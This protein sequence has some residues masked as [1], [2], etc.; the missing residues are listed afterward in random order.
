MIYGIGAATFV[1]STALL[2]Y[3]HCCR[4]QS[5]NQN[6]N[7]EYESRIDPLFNVFE[8]TLNYLRD[9]PESYKEDG[10]WRESGSKHFANAAY[11][12]VVDGNKTA[13]AFGPDRKFGNSTFTPHDAL[14]T[15]KM[16]LESNF[17]PQYFQGNDLLVA[18]KNLHID[19]LTVPAILK[20]HIDGLVRKGMT[21]EAS[22]LHNLLYL[23]YR[24]QSQDQLNRMNA[25]NVA[26]LFAPHFMRMLGIAESASATEFEATRQIISRLLKACLTSNVFTERFRTPSTS[27]EILP[28][29]R[30]RA[31]AQ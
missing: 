20:R 28:E 17:L 24:I 4:R 16:A 18:L 30:K 22:I 10:I 5:T 21:K 29:A 9:F 15:L 23:G 31:R 25:D 13:F 7:F 26:T 11:R 27:L 2:T 14:S 6:L 1:T 19:P 8:A 12:Y 3:Y